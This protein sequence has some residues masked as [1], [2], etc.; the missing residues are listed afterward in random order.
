M[1][2]GCGQ[3]GCSDPVGRGL[4]WYHLPG[5]ELGHIRYHEIPL[6]GLWLIKIIT[7][8]HKDLTTTMFF[9]TY[10]YNRKNCKQPKNQAS[11][12][13][14]INWYAHTME[15]CAVINKCLRDIP[16]VQ[17]LRFCT[18]SARGVGSN[19]GRGTKIPHA[20]QCGQ[21]KKSA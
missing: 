2:A 12:V 11:V 16:A 20:M 15:H 21:K 9:T 14:K 6:L 10:F 8:I 13:E 4:K 19:P 17:W 3:T 1:L 7:D 5:G 18:S